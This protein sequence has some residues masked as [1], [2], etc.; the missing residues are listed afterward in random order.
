MRGRALVSRLVGSRAL[1][2]LLALALIIAAVAISYSAENGLPFVP[3]YDI[4]TD[5]PDAAQLTKNSDVRIGGSRV[6]Q[7]LTIDAM[8]PTRGHP[9]F[10]RLALSLDGSVGRL[11]VD[12]IVR[13]RLGSLL[14]GEY[15]ELVPGH[16]RRTIPPGGRLGLSHAQA[17]VALDQA[18]RTFDSPTGRALQGA[19][20]G[21]GDTVAGRG[22][23]INDAISSTSELLPPLERVLGTLDDPGTRLARLV[24]ASAAMSGTLGP[25]APELVGLVVGARSTFV[26][27]D[28]A[29]GALGQTIDVLPGTETTGTVALR[30][31]EPVLANAAALARGLGPAA[32]LLVPTTRALD[33]I[34]RT[35]TPVARRVPAT[36]AP[37]E[38][39]LHAAQTFGTDP[40]TEGAL[41][42]LGA[43]DLGSLG[44]SLFLGL[45]AVLRTVAP[46]QLNCN[47]ASLWMRNLSSSFSE[48]DA[49]GTWIRMLPILDPAQSSKQ[50][51]PAADL[52]FNPYP[53]EDASEC[54]AGNEPYAS[55]QQ[56]GN[57]PGQQARSTAPTGPSRAGG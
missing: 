10:A 32:P 41:R 52:H 38:A 47:V 29:G 55:G 27:L 26:A 16:S 3:T 43:N 57:P 2:G 8:P 14:G 13:M 24:D 28:A 7:V 35:A 25:V 53:N 5:I 19:I 34:V 20:G 51:G 45:G 40:A 39:T 36:V 23:S 44:E 42:V 46:A 56:I 6:G 18:L 54:E 31:L 22:T 11:P 12:T 50:P 33:R 30:H 17:L 48:G 37:L 49:S 15:I 21:L 4:Q 1:N 9:P